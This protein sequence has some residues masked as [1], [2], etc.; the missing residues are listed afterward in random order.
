MIWKILAAPFIGAL[1]GYC[2]N[3][4]AVKMLFRP[5][6]AK[7]IGKFHVPFTPGVIPKGKS[8]L[9]RAMGNVVNTQL[10]T[11]E[12]LEDRLLSEEAVEIVQ[13][14]V[15]DT[16]DGLKADDSMTIH[17]LVSGKLDED[18]FNA[19]SAN[20][21]SFIVQKAY[22]K[23]KN[24]GL[25]VLISETIT[26]KM[27]E[28][29]GDSFLGKM[30]GDSMINMAKNAITQSVDIYIEQNGEQIIQKIV[31]SEAENLLSMPA[32]KIINNIENSGY[33]I[34]GAVLNVYTKI[35]REKA[36]TIINIINAGEI[37]EKT[38]EN[39]TNSQLEE[40]V[41]STM[42]TELSAIVNLG[43]LIGLVLG[44]INTAIYLI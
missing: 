12:T 33:D 4:L 34:N 16:I 39:M 43:A 10:L 25:G 20:I 41:M 15:N 31:S 26:S 14:I 44:L 13:N 8:R 9:A 18:Q 1:I 19:V 32:G 40:L 6:Q 38:I 30:M 28:A 24:A 22:D 23:I 37:A 36:D 17:K 21:Q 7:Y 29:I 42:K 3:W 2:T 5:D 27:Y 11:K 35:V